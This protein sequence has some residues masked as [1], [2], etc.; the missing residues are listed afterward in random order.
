MTMYLKK[1]YGVSDSKES[2]KLVSKLR[3][4]KVQNKI[5]NTH[6]LKN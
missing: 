6:P 1:G 2:I 3:E 4:E 5:N